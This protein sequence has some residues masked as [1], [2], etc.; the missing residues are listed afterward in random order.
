MREGWII[1]QDRVG[2]KRC[3]G[4]RRREKESKGSG[5]TAGGGL[6]S[7]CPANYIT[8]VS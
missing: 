6:V 1:S 7:S 5:G 3:N 4:N 2:H 8:F